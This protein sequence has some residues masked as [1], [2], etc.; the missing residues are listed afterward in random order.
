MISSNSPV[1]VLGAGAIGAVTAAMMARAGRKVELVC[2]HTQ[3]VDRALYPG[4]HIYGQGIDETVKIEA[5]AN[6]DELSGKKDI[7]FLATKATEALEAAK[8]L[9]Q[10]L[11]EDGYVVAMQNGII[12][13]ELAEIIGKSRVVGCTLN[14]G[15]T[16]L[17]PG[18]IELTSPGGIV[19]G[20]LAGGEA[21]DL[22]EIRG[23][24][25]IVRPTRTSDN[26]MGEL[27]AKLI[28]DSCINSIGAI[29]GWDLG[30]Q[31]ANRKVR[32][33]FMAI[34][35]EAVRVALALGLELTKSADGRIDFQ[36]LGRGRGLVGMYKK[37]RF[38]KSIAANYE[39][40]KSPSL[41]SLQRGR[42]TEVEFLN[43]YI[44]Q[45][46]QDAGIPTPV[47]Q[48]VVDM[49]HEIEDGSRRISGENVEHLPQ[50]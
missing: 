9:P 32:S 50:R 23:F 24:L 46:G 6:T 15:S 39:R 30:K 45:K 47:N 22:E 4:F 33:L 21:N 36:R 26:M 1:A 49:I 38:V 11:N 42:R 34:S 12:E 43:G 25:D 8:Q 2:K 7:V 40:I 37:H 29:T 27:W 5:V 16:M 13:E 14:W 41:Q 31:V 28:M 10:I 35:K 3:F 17:E 19:V 44:C 48:A 18:E 20:F